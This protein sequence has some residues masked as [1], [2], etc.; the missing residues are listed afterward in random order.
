MT[1][2]ATEIA[3][4]K[5]IALVAHDNKKQDLLDWARYNRGTLSKHDLLATGT[6]GKLLE[7]ALQTPIAKLQSGPLGGDLQ[8]GAKIAQGEVDFV[9]F[10]WDPLE[11]QPHDPDVKALIRIAV[12]WNIPVACNRATADFVISSPL[13]Q[14]SYER[15]LPDYEGYRRR[16]EQKGA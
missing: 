2:I 5:R 3:S 13:M 16:L 11:A 7:D 9:I 6:T 12:V 1:A 15:E 10:F 8:I 4:R 14:S